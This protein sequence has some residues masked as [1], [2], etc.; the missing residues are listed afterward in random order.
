MNGWIGTQIEVKKH[1]EIS[2]LNM[3]ELELFK[4]LLV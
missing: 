1:P 3:G 2:E 4:L